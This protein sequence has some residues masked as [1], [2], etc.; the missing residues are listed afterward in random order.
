MRVDGTGAA[1]SPRE[2]TVVVPTR[3]RGHLV[4]DAVD[5]ALGQS[6]VDVEVLVV[7]DGSRDPVGLPADPR[8]R[9]VRHLRPRG[10]AAARNLG[11]TLAATPWI[12]FLDDDDRARPTWLARSLTAA[13]SS[14]LPGPV[15]VLSAVA[16]VD[17][18][19][20]VRET[21]TPPAASPRGRPFSLAPPQPGRSYLSKQTLVVP[22]AVLLAID[23]LDESFRSRVVTELFWRLN[24]VCSLQGIEDVT[25]ELRAHDGPRLSGDPGRRQASFR[26]LV[27]VHGDLL[28][29]HPEGAARL[30]AAHARSSFGDARYL[31]AAIAATRSLRLAPLR[32]WRDARAARRG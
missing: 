10:V 2:V 9:V 8:L 3:D 4:A 20:T 31:A 24:A 5:T 25:Y 30:H 14:R 17:R 32:P 11:I 6:D 19:G 16:V 29:A 27:T 1:P 12:A 7:D 15:G 23:G 21:R 22:R 26:Q 18:T 28:A 13:A